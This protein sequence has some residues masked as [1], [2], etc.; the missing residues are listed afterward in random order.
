[1]QWMRPWLLKGKKRKL[2]KALSTTDVLPQDRCACEHFTS[3]PH[4][5]HSKTGK[6]F[7]LGFESCS[8]GQISYNDSNPQPLCQRHL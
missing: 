4:I 2:V 5:C 8:E 3:F 7:P 6:L 1:M